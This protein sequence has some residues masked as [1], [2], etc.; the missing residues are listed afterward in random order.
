MTRPTARNRSDTRLALS[1]LLTVLVVWEI[2][3]HL[4]LLATPFASS[5][6]PTF[7]SIVGKSLRELSI[8]Y[9]M[10]GLGNGKYGAEPGY[11]LTLVVIAYH[12]LRTLFRIVCG[13]LL[14][15]VLGIGLGLVVKASRE[16]SSLVSWQIQIIRIVPQMALVPLFIIWFG[17]T[18]LGFIMFIGYGVFSALFVNTISAVDNVSPIYQKFALTL[19][20][21]RARMFVDVVLP[22]IIPELLGGIKVIVGQAWALSLAAEFLASQ[23]G[24]GRI[25]I[26]A[27]QRLDTGQI[28][29]VLLLY[30]AYTLLFLR[31]VYWFGNRM[32]RWKQVLEK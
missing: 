23:N 31:I 25:I 15:G 6:L 27:R 10:G 24:L 1:G 19:G 2:A 8:F 20:A 7:E 26:L 9:G 28:I 16:A 22:G 13:F 14:G 5:I 32:T 21:S 4:L 17:G 30:M 29:I 3:A 11:G 18:E 12:S